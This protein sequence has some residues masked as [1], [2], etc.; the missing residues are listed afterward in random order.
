[1]SHRIESPEHGVVVTM[2][3]AASDCL[4]AS[5][6]APKSVPS[7]HSALTT[8]AGLVSVTA[9]SWRVSH[10]PALRLPALGVV[11]PSGAVRRSWSRGPRR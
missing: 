9:S 11:S 4:A 10:V 6:D 2:P 3:A 7:R 5:A 8:A 1:M